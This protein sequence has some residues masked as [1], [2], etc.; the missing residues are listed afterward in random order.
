MNKKTAAVGMSGGVDSTVAAMLLLQSGYEVVGLTMS[1]YDGS[2]KIDKP[3]KDACYSP[4]EAED[5]EAVREV[6]GRL[7]IRH[8]VIDVRQ[9]YKRFVLDY[10]RQ[11]YLVGRTPN[12]CVQCNHSIKFG[13]M[14]TKA[15]ES[16]I[17]FDVFATGHYAR[18]E[19]D[20]KGRPLLKSALDLH[21]DQ[22]YFI[23]GIRRELLG[24]LMF[25]LGDKTKLQ[26]RELARQ[27]GLSVAEKAESQD[28][29]ACDSYAPVFADSNVQSGDIVDSTGKVL[30]KHKGIVYYTI[31]QRKGMGI[32]SPEPLYVVS[33]DA[34]RNRIVVGSQSELYSATALVRDFNLMMPDDFEFPIRARAKIRQ[35]HQAADAMVERLSDG[36]I[37]ATFDQPQM[38]VTAG[39]SL[40]VYL[41]D[42]VVGGGV[43]VQE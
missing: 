21:K 35:A 11:E 37:R 40:V 3:R 25:P 1:I 18:I 28:F 7:G 17:N 2:V 32:S 31:G 13:F 36:S 38:S 42:T 10:F 22:S 27:A 41:D 8:Q 33:I 43:I 26:V 4:G 5:I 34:K 39:Q 20:A 15:R 9:E 23:H 29:I 19:P 14:L 6:C 16:G 12:P 24:S 30:G